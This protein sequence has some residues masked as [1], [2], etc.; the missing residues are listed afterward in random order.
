MATRTRPFP[1][2]HDHPR[3]PLDIV[4]IGAGG[5]VRAAHLPA[6]ARAGFHVGGVYDVKRSASSSAARAAGGARVFDSLAEALAEPDVVFDV[7][8]PPSELAQILASAKPGSALLVQK[9]FGRDLAEARRLSAIVKRR[10]LTVAVNFQ[11]RFS[12]GVLALRDALAR[13]ALGTVR[14]AEMRVVTA[15]PWKRWTFLRRAPR[16][17]ILYHSI[18]YLDLARALF[19]EPREVVARARPD[20]AYKGFADTRS[21]IELW[22]ARGLRFT[23]HTNHAHACATP[24]RRISELTIEGSRGAARVSLGVNKDYDAPLPDTFETARGTVWRAHRLSGSWFP[25]AF[26]GPMSNLQR[27][28]SGEE[29]VLWTRAADALRTM[30]LVEAC[31]ESS[32]SSSRP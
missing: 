9:P 5:I 31:Y 27:F 25:D 11:L 1:R 32:A 22:F 7:A 12:P 19:G 17:E 29:R 24:R 30:E 28:V 26:A 18:H 21:T 14:E 6:Y 10:R 13:G 16:L 20:P 23:I 4:S 15:T 8:V 3:R 2:R